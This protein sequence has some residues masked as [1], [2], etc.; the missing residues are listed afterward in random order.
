MKLWE[1]TLF[2]FLQININGTRLEPNDFFKYIYIMVLILL[3]GLA[4]IKSGDIRLCS[5]Q[6]KTIS[7]S[8]CSGLPNFQSTRTEISSLLERA[9]QVNLA[10]RNMYEAPVSLSENWYSGLLVF[11]SLCPTTCEAHCSVGTKFQ[12]EGHSCK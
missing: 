9:M 8:C 12:F 6:N 11:R 5:F 2:F 7:Y 4:F 3:S 10:Q 1:F